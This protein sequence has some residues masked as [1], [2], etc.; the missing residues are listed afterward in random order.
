MNKF[1]GIGRLTK[2]LELK[3]TIT[4][5]ACVNFT[6]AVDKLVNGVKEADFINCVAW[7]KQAENL[8]KYCHK[9]SKIAVDGSIST[10]TYDKEDGTKVYITEIN[11]R[12]IEFFR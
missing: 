3:Y 8:V 5:K 9:G 4:N 2:S 11:S 12:M 10:R 1:I 6:I 7:E